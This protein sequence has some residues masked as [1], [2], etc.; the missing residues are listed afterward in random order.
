MNLVLFDFDGVIGDS[1]PVFHPAFV[2]ACR[3]VGFDRFSASGEFLDLFEGNLIQKIMDAGLPEP[4]KQPLLDALA[5]EVAAAIDEV[6]PFPGMPEAVSA[7]AAAGPVYV[8]TSNVGA[9]IARFLARHGVTGVLG[10]LGADHEP[11]KTVKIRAAAA[12]HPDCAP[13]YVGDT[14]GDMLE[15]AEAGAATVAVDWGWHD[16]ARLERGRPSRH[17]ATPEELLRILSAG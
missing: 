8:V 3:A 15:G 11:S 7:L 14:L 13:W 6:A 2:R 16:R 17:A 5:A 1:F 10:V 9:P 12:A 4:R